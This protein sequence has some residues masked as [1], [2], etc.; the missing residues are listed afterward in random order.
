MLATLDI[1]K[2]RDEQGVEIEPVV[3]FENT[4]LRTPSPFACDT[5]PRSEEA[6]RLI[7]EGE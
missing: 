7:M 2:A 6:L 3:R 5:R 1:C 4:V